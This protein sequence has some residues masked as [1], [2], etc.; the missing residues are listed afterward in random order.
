VI[1]PEAFLFVSVIGNAEGSGSPAE[2]TVG[3]GASSE[4]SAYGD[5][6]YF[7]YLQ[8]LSTP[9][10]LEVQGAQEAEY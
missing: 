1:R 6:S 9:P 4:G 7:W 10:K 5:L 3:H 2:E 8:R